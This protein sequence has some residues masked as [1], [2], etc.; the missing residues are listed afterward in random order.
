MSTDAT[1]PR[2]V[3]KWL[4]SLDLSMG[5]KH[6]RR[7]FA[8]GFLI[9]EILSRYYPSD[10]KSNSLDTGTSHAAKK[11]NWALVEKICRRV[12]IKA[13]SR[14][15]IERVMRAEESKPAVDVV[16]SMYGQLTKRWP[17]STSQK[18]LSGPTSEG[19]VMTVHPLATQI[20][21]L[22]PAEDKKAQKQSTQNSSA[23]GMLLESLDI[24]TSVSA[25]S[26]SDLR[27]KIGDALSIVN[28]DTLPGKLH[29]LHEHICDLLLPASDPTAAQLLLDLHLPLFSSY[30]PISS[31][32]RGA[33]IVLCFVGA[34]FRSIY[35]ARALA[36]LSSATDFINVVDQI[37]ETGMLKVSYFAAVLLAFVGEDVTDA[38]L[39]QLLLLIKQRCMIEKPTPETT[40]SER[41]IVENIIGGATTPLPAIFPTQLSTRQI[42]SLQVPRE[43]ALMMFLCAFITQL[44]DTVGIKETAS[45]CET[46]SRHGSKESQRFQGFFSKRTQSMLL[47]VSEIMNSVHGFMRRRSSQPAWSD[48]SAS[49]ELSAALLALGALIEAGSMS[50]G[51]ELVTDAIGFND[52]S[53]ASSAS[54]QLLRL[55]HQTECP[56]HVQK[57]YVSIITTVLRCGTGSERESDAY[58]SVAVGLLQRLEGD[59]L[60]TAILVLAPLTSRYPSLCAPLCRALVELDEVL[61]SCM[62]RQTAG[63][64]NNQSVHTE[65]LVDVINWE[66]PVFQRTVLTATQSWWAFGIAMGVVSVMESG[67]TVSKPRVLLP[68]L[69]ILRAAVAR[70]FH[71]K[72]GVLPTQEVA[73]TWESAVFARAVSP[74]ILALGYIE[75]IDAAIDILDAHAVCSDLCGDSGSFTRAVGAG[76]I[77]L[78][79][80]AS[81]KRNEE[82]LRTIRGWFNRWE[83]KANAVGAHGVEMV[84]RCA[85]E[86]IPATFELLM[87]PAAI[88]DN[89]KPDEKQSASCAEHM[90]SWSTRNGSEDTKLY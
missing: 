88:L 5:L 13:P 33:C 11:Y 57:S 1:I 21:D 32:F 18:S 41:E 55:I 17:D 64:I 27:H 14:T 87:P 86:L 42:P 26:T 77:T 46:H 9:G 45:L 47:F 8:N 35:K 68:H 80:W 38:D 36:K 12:G 49:V 58:V 44:H 29:I 75:T 4:H 40:S 90:V 62:L 23:I 43:P 85:L 74:V 61:R 28:L 19:V 7:D 48:R 81:E 54:V 16:V 83:G 15:L 52:A 78:V 60:R 30:P 66:L 73:S 76:L 82:C 3:L 34:V 56:S 25:S 72:Q 71:L 65:S 53:Q 69:E 39:L 31:T 50:V 89:N 63:G 22:Q 10:L 59:A 6:H 24:P 79:L 70:S 37:K 67:D 51:S 20:L 2:E 84:K